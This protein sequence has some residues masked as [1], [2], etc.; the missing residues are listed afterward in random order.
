MRL[1]SL[2]FRLIEE[3]DSTTGVTGCGVMIGNN[4]N[5]IIQPEELAVD[6]LGRLCCHACRHHL[7]RPE[8]VA[9]GVS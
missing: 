1:V 3:M 8:D 7:G 6:H 5:P 4:S 2:C 9:G